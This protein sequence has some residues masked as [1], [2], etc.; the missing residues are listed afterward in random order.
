[1]VRSLRGRLGLSQSDL[2]V[3][4]GVTGQSVYQWE[5]KGGS[6]KL[7]EKTKTALQR[8]RQMGKREAR[9]ELKKL[10]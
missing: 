5:R 10:S 4:L 7:R 2:A 3:L 8:A 6:L 9:A 1:M